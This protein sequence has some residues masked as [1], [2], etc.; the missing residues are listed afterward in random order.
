MT[1]NE[2]N[3]QAAPVYA[4]DPVWMTVK[5]WAELHNETVSA[6]AK[7][8]Q[9]GGLITK[10]RKSDRESFRIN[11]PLEKQKALAQKY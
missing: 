4:I 7:Q 10:P 1:K 11:Y 8:C 6:V 5:Q 2:V 9:T 3:A